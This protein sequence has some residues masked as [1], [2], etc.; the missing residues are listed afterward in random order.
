MTMDPIQAT[1]I[2]LDRSSEMEVEI[3][4]DEIVPEPVPEPTPPK[5]KPTPKW[6][7]RKCKHIVIIGAGGVGFYLTLALMAEGLDQD[8]I[9]YDPDTFEGGNGHR[10]L[11]KVNNPKLKKVD[12]LKA[13]CQVTFGYERPKTIPDYFTV[14]DASGLNSSYL[15]VDA[16]DMPF[17]ERLD[18]WDAFTKTGAKGIRVSYDGNGIVCIAYGPPFSPPDDQGGYDR[19][20]STAQSFLAGGAGAEFIK[21][22]LKGEKMDEMQIEIGTGL[23]LQPIQPVQ[24]TQIQSQAEPVEIPATDAEN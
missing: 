18:I 14:L 3:M 23:Q 6:T 15:V 22:L 12:M 24:Q 5:P 11:P 8:I 13:T 2:S 10:R 21:A 17:R 1:E 9:V 19:M 4:V 7:P 20:P 16:S